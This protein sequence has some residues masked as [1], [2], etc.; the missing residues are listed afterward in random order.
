MNCKNCNNELP[1]K[2]ASLGYKVC[3]SCSDVET[4][5]CVN[6]I[7]HKT[8]NTVQPLPK[9]Q[10]A[11]IN[12]I[13]DRKRFGTVLKGGSKS[14]TYNPGKDI[15]IGCSTTFVGSAESYNIVGEES[16]KILDTKGY[17][18]ATLFI[19]KQVKNYYISGSQ[20][21]KLKRLI[22]QISVYEKQN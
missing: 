3:V 19:D 6:I 14:S 21:F 13:G 8:G 15:K 22:N 7:N 9:S 4:Y 11:A 5:G 16:M 17:E 20:A 2:R 10:A 12:K 18:A 1:Q